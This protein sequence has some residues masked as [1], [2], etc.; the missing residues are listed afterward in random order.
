MKIRAIKNFRMKA[1][2]NVEIQTG[3]ELEVSPDVG[4][5]WIKKGYAIPFTEK[6]EKAVTPEPEK[7]TK[8]TS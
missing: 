2:P 3:S 8:K 1:V 6:A 4:A 5:E 7:R